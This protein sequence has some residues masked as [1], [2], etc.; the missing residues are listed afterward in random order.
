MIWPFKGLFAEYDA[1]DDFV[2]TI[3][4]ADPRYKNLQ[5][6]RVL[7]LANIFSTEYV[8]EAIEYCVRIGKCSASEV[9]AFLIYRCGD[10]FAKKYLSKNAFFAW[11]G[12]AVRDDAQKAVDRFTLKRYNYFTEQALFSRTALCFLGIT[13]I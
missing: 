12:Y 11:Y 7:S 2:D 5:F 3:T 9:A 4:E 1:I 8:A 13:V 10:D 6:R